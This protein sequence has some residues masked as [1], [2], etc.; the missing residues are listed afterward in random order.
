MKFALQHCEAGLCQ[1]SALSQNLM[2][3]THANTF[4][5]LEVYNPEGDSRDTVSLKTTTSVFF[6]VWFSNKHWSIKC[7]LHFFF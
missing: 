4:T 2:Q 6:D 5:M 7:T 3:N 1:S